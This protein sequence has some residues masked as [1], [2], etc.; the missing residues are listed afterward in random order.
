M[1]ARWRARLSPATRGGLFYFG[2]YGAAATYMPFLSVF[3]A[4]RGLSGQEIGILAAFGPLMALVA[5]PALS[6]LADR[7]GWRLEML[8]AAMAASALSL[9]ALLVPNSFWGLLVVVAMLAIASSPVGPIA[10]GLL[11]RMA[12]RRGLSYGQMRL[13]GSLSYALVA[14]GGGALW[15]EAGYRVVLPVAAALFLALM[16]VAPLLDDERPTTTE[17]PSSLRVV[18]RDSRLR[19][20]LVATFLLGLGMGMGL[21]FGGIYMDR[22]S[23]GQ[24]LVGLFAGLTAF[25]ELPTM[26][27]SEKLIRRLSAPW[28]LVLAYVLQGSGYIGFLYIRQPELLLGMAVLQGLGFGLFLPTTVRLVDMLAPAEWA[29]TFQGLLSA[30]VW[31]LAPLVAGL[32]GGSL[33]DAG[34][35]PAVFMAC[36]IVTAG[37]VLL[38]AGAQLAGIFRRAEEPPRD[39]HDPPG[40][41]EAGPSPA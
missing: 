24:F 23:G 40:A 17:A 37:A 6:A 29:T 16:L 7:R 27:W 1:F 34:G 11:A 9:L 41:R 20:V 4:R 31:G 13:W 15:Q 19:I 33:Y 32:L 3:F 35:A 2:Y 10:D 8:S 28:T 21:T 38:L 5:A 14:A 30:G 39:S 25:C 12:A 26:H 18:T 22:L 36:V